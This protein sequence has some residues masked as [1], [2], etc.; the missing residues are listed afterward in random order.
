[1][2]VIEIFELQELFK[3][4]EA[5]DKLGFDYKIETAREHGQNLLGHDITTN[6]WRFEVW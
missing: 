5:A 2:K 6:Y 1:M 3:I 4:I